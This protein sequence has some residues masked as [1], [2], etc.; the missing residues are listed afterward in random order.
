MGLHKNLKLL[1][2][3]PARWL[4]HGEVSKRLVS[5]FES[6]ADALD[7]LINGKAAPDIKRIRDKLLGLNIILMLLLLSDFLA[8][9]NQFSRHLQTRNQM[10]MALDLLNLHCHFYSCKKKRMMLSR[11][12]RRHNLIEAEDLLTLI[13]EFKSNVK[14][15]FM[16]DLIVELNDAL[17]INDPVLLAFDVFNIYVNFKVK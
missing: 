4:S 5:R 3:A 1:K 8:H 9:V 7:T 16:S 12:L 6:L 2:A 15:P 13:T 14:T 11:R 17:K 10:L